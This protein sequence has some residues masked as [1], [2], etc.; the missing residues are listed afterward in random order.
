MGMGEI[1]RNE[2][3]LVFSQCFLLNQIIVFPFAHIFDIIS[4][5]AAD[6]EEPKIVISG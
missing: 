5:F 3:F 1:A 2:Q 6:S 4:L